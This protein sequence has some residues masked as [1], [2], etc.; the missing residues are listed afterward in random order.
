MVRKSPEAGFSENESESGAP[1][2][3]GSL[4]ARRLAAVSV[5]MPSEK[6]SDGS[7]SRKAIEKARN[8]RG[9]REAHARLRKGREAHIIV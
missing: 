2:R 5:R 8:A 4:L 1:I 3:R 6:G 7:N 9:I